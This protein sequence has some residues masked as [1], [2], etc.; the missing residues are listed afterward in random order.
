MLAHAKYGQLW[1]FYDAFRA[2]SAGGELTPQ[3]ITA[4]YALAK[5]MFID[6]ERIKA[7]QDIFE[8]EEKLRQKRSKLLF[9]KGIDTAIEKVNMEQ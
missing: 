4:I 6:E 8:Q 2:A 1:L 9:P 5:K 7:V 3:K